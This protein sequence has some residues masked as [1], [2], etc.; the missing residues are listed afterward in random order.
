MN[1]FLSLSRR[2]LIGAALSAGLLAPAMAQEN[3][4]RDVNA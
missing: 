4:S 3:G 2:C 1:T